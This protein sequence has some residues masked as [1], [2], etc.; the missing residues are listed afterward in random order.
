M[1]TRGP[2]ISSCSKSEWGGDGEPQEAPRGETHQGE[3]SRAWEILP[4][5]G[6]RPRSTS[7]SRAPISAREQPTR[8]PTSPRPPGPRPGRPLIAPVRPS[9]PGAPPPPLE[10]RHLPAPGPRRNASCGTAGHRGEAQD[11]APALP[12]GSRGRRGASSRAA[13]TRRLP[14]PRAP[15]PGPT[16]GSARAQCSRPGCAQAS[17]LGPA[18]AP[19]FARLRLCAPAPLDRRK[20]CR[21]LQAQ[22]CLEGFPGSPWRAV[23]TWGICPAQQNQALKKPW[24]VQAVIWGCCSRHTLLWPTFSLLV[25]FG[26]P[27]ALSFWAGRHHPLIP[28]PPLPATSCSPRP[29]LILFR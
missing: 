22:G 24:L 10:S 3:Q 29:H 20:V 12:R 27:G 18:H 8:A 23:D 1:S 9:L 26:L 13:A 14:R 17:A 19:A 11:R 15:E 2:R 16:R 28:P 6:G 4:G 25:Q 5:G 7:P 21:C